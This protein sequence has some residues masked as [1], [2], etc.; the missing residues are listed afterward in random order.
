M[1]SVTES[2]V[3]WLAV[4]LLASQASALAYAAFRRALAG[5]RASYR[6]V[7][8][9]AYGA[10]PPLMAMLAVCLMNYPGWD[11]ILV[12]AHCHAGSCAPHAPEFAGTSLGGVALI[13]GASLALSAGL[14]AMLHGL[15]AGRRKL[16]TLSALS[17]QDGL[18]DYRVLDSP[19]LV[20][21]CCGLF[22]PQVYVSRGLL[23]RLTPQQL[24]AVLAH[25][26]A[27]RARHDN[28]RTWLLHS[29]TVAWPPRSRRRI[30]RDF[31][32]DTELVCDSVA[33]LQVGDRS[34]VAAAIRALQGHA[35]EKQAD[36]RWELAFGQVD[37]TVR[38]R[39]L[40]RSAANFH[41]PFRPW[42]LLCVLSLMQMSILTGLSHFAVE[43][44]TSTGLHFG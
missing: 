8:T 20:A 26:N 37:A 40:R 42:L 33:A 25:E 31:S 23:Q 12:P 2:V 6:T 1:M 43:W 24:Q 35:G 22:R 14:L 39:E 18:R 28:L 44:I 5:C 34:Q 16:T 38:I 36:C 19:A 3:L 29:I 17:V 27:H 30:R 9:L 7:L 15:R 13:S 11:G 4:A 21:W 32:A 41:S 10:M